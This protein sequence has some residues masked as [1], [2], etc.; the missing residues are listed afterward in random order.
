[1]RSH[2]LAST[3]LSS[4][5]PPAAA[6]PTFPVPPTDPGA[7]AASSSSPSRSSST[8]A[9]A[10]AAAGSA[11]GTLLVRTVDDGSVVELSSLDLS[12][13]RRSSA[14]AAGPSAS[15]IT[16]AVVRF[17]LPAAVVGSPSV[18]VL[19]SAKTTIV[20]CLTTTGFLYR[21]TLPDASR[22]ADWPARLADGHARGVS[23][24]GDDGMDD[25]DD[26]VDD[27]LDG[28]GGG[29]SDRWA[30]ESIIHGLQESTTA[31]GIE[32]V[33]SVVAVDDE[34][35]LVGLRSGSLL[36][37]DWHS[38][39]SSWSETN[40]KPSSVLSSLSALIPFGAADPTAFGPQAIHSLVALSPSTTAASAASGSSGCGST[41]AYDG[42]PLAFALSADGRL[43]AWNVLSGT[44]SRPLDLDLPAGELLTAPP[45]GPAEA[46]WL[47]LLGRSPPLDRSHVGASALVVRSGPSSTAGSNNGVVDV[48]AVHLPGRFLLFGVRPSTRP[49]GPPD[50]LSLLTV[51][52]PDQDRSASSSSSALTR[53][54]A[55][56]RPSPLSA[57]TSAL[58]AFDLVSSPST[59]SIRL[60]SAWSRPPGHQTAVVSLDLVFGHDGRSGAPTA[61]AASP[62][63][64]R[65]A[66]SLSP[67]AATASAFAELVLAAE[68]GP[69]AGESSSAATPEHV[70]RL[71]LDHLFYPG[72]F[73]L[74]ALTTALDGYISTVLAQSSSSSVSRSVRQQIGT[75]IGRSTTTGG[76]GV[77]SA[78]C[79]SYASLPARI[80]AVV[81]CQLERAIDPLTGAV[82]ER[83]HLEACLAEWVGF[84]AR[85]DEAEQRARWAL[86]AVVLHPSTE[87]EEEPT[88]EPIWAVVRR[89]GLLVP[90]ERAGPAEDAV[91]TGRL[92]SPSSSSSAASTLLSLA[93]DLVGTT[94]SGAG[95]SIS[96]GPAAELAVPYPSLV[97]VRS[98]LGRFAAGQ[99]PLGGLSVED[100]VL[101]LWLGRCEPGLAPQ[102]A[103]RLEALRSGHGGP[104]T[105]ARG[106]TELLD[107]LGQTADGANAATGH[108]DSARALSPLGAA[109]A[110]SAVLE[111]AA[112]RERLA[113]G[114]VLV[115][116]A[117]GSQT[118]EDDPALVDLVRTL[119]RAVRSWQE[120][121]A[122]EWVAKTGVEV[123]V[124]AA[125]P[126][127]VAAQAGSPEWVDRF[128]GLKVGGTTSS[129][130]SNQAALLPPPSILA[131]LLSVNSPSPSASL[132][133]TASAVLRSWTALS[134]P[135][136]DRSP[137]LALVSRVLALGQPGRAAELA[138]RYDDADGTGYV[139]ARAALALGQIESSVRLFERAAAVFGASLGLFGTRRAA[140]G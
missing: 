130:S 138:D 33:T 64:W 20:L 53:S 117:V 86:T 101:D 3:A 83:E 72:R 9:L 119:D 75:S 132:R 43:R 65:E 82:R 32:Q 5:Q 109:L 88:E 120:A 66:T 42:P 139:Q 69:S 54:S 30:T 45:A 137:A 67:P 15:A 116:G 99:A 51:P 44:A 71:F 21:L 79:R 35:V 111:C 97:H 76:G 57:S 115:L 12:R 34:C 4:L 27:R 58:R 18:H 26:D 90:V 10:T 14:P 49:S 47:R 87:E 104:K 39:A 127:A 123:G 129:S 133:R 50:L 56:A 17:A 59:G 107:L 80:G 98:D 78:L 7:A 40:L 131:S 110:G 106:A 41:M 6:V 84:L 122:L 37:L 28:G 128:G 13:R 23:D 121:A 93:L 63:G 55:S 19:R 94:N 46:G 89:D 77:P 8:S 81:G 105:V 16:D 2:A 68:D 134:Q 95:G 112:A 73:A 113:L 118:A 126:T 74:S 38:S 91:A 85:A 103:A 24:D 124:A 22:L 96:S 31:G 61:A 25:D 70:A 29:G 62:D 125:A 52:G 108:G 1:M 92:A 140:S 11:D 102:T 60:W 100:A 135:G 36:K 114:L 48:L 136:A